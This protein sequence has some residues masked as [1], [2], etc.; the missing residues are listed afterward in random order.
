M[1]Q[2]FES[3]VDEVGDLGLEDQSE[4]DGDRDE[5]GNLDEFHRPTEI[6]RIERHAGTLAN[7]GFQR[8]G[9]GIGTRYERSI[10]KAN[11]II[12]QFWKEYCTPLC[13]PLANNS[14]QFAPPQ[15]ILHTPGIGNISQFAPPKTT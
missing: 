14:F 13:T 4:R 8:L 15:I 7:T 12:Y 1:A 6:D 11:G 9:E 3:P 10:P 2:A 5:D